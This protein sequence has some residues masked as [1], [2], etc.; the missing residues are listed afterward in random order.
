[1]ALLFRIAQI[2]HHSTVVFRAVRSAFYFP[3]SAIPH[4]TNTLFK[5]HLW[6]VRRKHAT[7]QNGWY[8]GA[9]SVCKNWH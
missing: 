5:S 6:R 3:H 8:N 2:T 4:F 7:A 9:A 1:L